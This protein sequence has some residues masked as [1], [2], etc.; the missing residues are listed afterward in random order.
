MRSITAVLRRGLFATFTAS[1]VG[2]AAVVAITVSSSPVMPSATAAPDPC[3]A[4]EVARTV[5]SVAR[6]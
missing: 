4:S 5:G 2:G 6:R 1:A 3:A